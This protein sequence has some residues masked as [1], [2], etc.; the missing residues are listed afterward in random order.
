MAPQG[1]KLAVS[2]KKAAVIEDLEDGEILSSDEDAEKEQRQP[3]DEQNDKK[4]E[5]KPVAKKPVSKSNPIVGSAL[6][7]EK[8]NMENKENRVD[9]KKK[10]IESI[11]L[12]SHDVHPR[13]TQP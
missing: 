7:K 6:M 5:T 10:G 13:R 9:K 11:I 3:Q 12:L 4:K 2:K 8:K 1:Q